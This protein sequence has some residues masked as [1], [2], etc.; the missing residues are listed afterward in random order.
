MFPRFRYHPTEAPQGKK[1]T[2]EAE[3]HALGP[4]WVDTPAKFPAPGAVSARPED[5]IDEVT[6]TVK[7]R[8]KPKET[9]Q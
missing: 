1:F 2:D 5:V 9:I 7:A 3:F 8:R 4:E 6:A